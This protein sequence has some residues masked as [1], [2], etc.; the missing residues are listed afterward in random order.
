MMNQAFLTPAV[1]P[2]LFLILFVFERFFPLRKAKR[3]LLKRVYVNLMTAALAF[4]IAGVL[5]RPLALKM[6]EWTGAQKISL[7]YLFP[8]P[9][10]LKFILGFLLMDLSFYY[11]HR[12]NHQIPFLWRFHNTHHID[13]DLDVS[14]SFRFHYGEVFFSTFFRVVQVVVIGVSLSTFLIY[15]LVFQSCTLF[16]HSNIRL[17]LMAER[18]LNLFIV[19][20][21]MH[22]IHHSQ[23]ETETNANYCVVFRWWDALHRTLNLNISQ[24]TLKIGVPAYKEPRANLLRNVL[25]LPFQ[26]QRDYWKEP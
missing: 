21:R 12:M 25:T 18:I 2:C 10:Q 6:I 26:K 7:L 19:T 14:T 9:S 5:V 1:I 20:P 17:P 16:H 15:E 22:G 4:F 24:E 3:N 23:V 13:P 11:W 8:L